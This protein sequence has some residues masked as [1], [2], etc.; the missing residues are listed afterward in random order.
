[1]STVPILPTTCLPFKLSHVVYLGL[2]CRSCLLSTPVEA[3]GST[4]VYTVPILPT[5]PTPMEAWGST[6]VYCADPAYHV[7]GTVGLVDTCLSPSSCL[8]H[9]GR[10]GRHVI[11]MSTPLEVSMWVG[12]VGKAGMVDTCLP[13]PSGCL[14]GRHSRHGRHISTPRQVS[15]W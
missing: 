1:M 3:W 7:V 9:C 2:L 6:D 5:M 15:M 14:C 13:P 4:S 8:C 10:Q 12:T 11:H